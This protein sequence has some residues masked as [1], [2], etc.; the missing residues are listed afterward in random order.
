[1]DYIL[2]DRHSNRGLHV[3]VPRGA[4]GGI[5]NHYLV[6]LRVKIF[7]FRVFRKEEMLW[8]GK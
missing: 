5:S 1:M 3:N 8:V 2:I 7:I 4:V 6:V